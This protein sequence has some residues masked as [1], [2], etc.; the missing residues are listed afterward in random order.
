M[1]LLISLLFLF[2]VGCAKAQNHKCV[3]FYYRQM[4][5]DPIEDTTIVKE[6]NSFYNIGDTV[7]FH[8]YIEGQK[9]DVAYW[10]EYKKYDILCRMLKKTADS[11]FDVNE[12]DKAIYFKKQYEKYNDS[13]ELYNIL[14]RKK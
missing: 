1:K 3:H 7:I 6:A 13:C 10:H 14:M 12:F 4:F 2:S 8:H 5:P 9:P 11:A